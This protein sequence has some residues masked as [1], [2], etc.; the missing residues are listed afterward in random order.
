VSR[1]A[2]ARR[3]VDVIFGCMV[4]ASCT[5]C[6]RLHF[7]ANSDGGT[8]NG[9]D[10]ATAACHRHPMLGSS[11]CLSGTAPYDLWIFREV[12]GA[13]VADTSGRGCIPLTSAGVVSDDGISTAGGSITSQLGAATQLFG[14]LASSQQ[15]TLEVWLHTTGKVASN[16]PIGAIEDGLASR[17]EID[18]VANGSQGTVSGGGLT[19]DNSVTNVTSGQPVRLVVYADASTFHYEADGVSGGAFTAVNFASWQASSS[20]IAFGPWSG[21]VVRAAI[22]DRWFM[23]TEDSCLLAAGPLAIP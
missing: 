16:T 4:I 19:I 13:T 22:Y 17:A 1:L 20:R 3:A 15:V 21:V 12:S 6:G 2:I 11:G 5:A 10:G 14:A 23:A 7:D 18:Q 9:G 8:S